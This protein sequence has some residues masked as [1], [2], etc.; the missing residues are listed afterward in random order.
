MCQDVVQRNR[1]AISTLTCNKLYTPKLRNVQRKTKNLWVC[2]FRAVLSRVARL[3]DN[4]EVTNWNC[5]E[6]PR[7]I[8]GAWKFSSFAD[9]GTKILLLACQ[10]ETI[11]QHREWFRACWNLVFPVGFGTKIR[12]MAS[13]IGV[14]SGK[15]MRISHFATVSNCRNF[16]DALENIPFRNSV[17][18]W[19]FALFLSS[20][21]A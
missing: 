8:L 7:T 13:Q 14:V 18:L 2:W 20:S 19:N 5:R 15:C 1:S 9:S 21:Y 12:L 16:G 10:I 6:T 4:E 3:G 11:A 17:K